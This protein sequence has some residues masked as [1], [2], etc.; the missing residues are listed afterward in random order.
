MLDYALNSKIFLRFLK[1]NYCF[2]R[3]FNEIRQI[4]LFNHD[5]DLDQVHFNELHILRDVIFFSIPLENGWE[6]TDQKWTRIY[7]QHKEEELERLLE[8]AEKKYGLCRLQ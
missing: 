8:I 3:Y 6:R 1:E 4:L 5:D 2:H 7:G